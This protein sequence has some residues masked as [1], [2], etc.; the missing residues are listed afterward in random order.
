MSRFGSWSSPTL[1]VSELVQ[2]SLFWEIWTSPNFLIF[3]I[4]TS[5]D[6][7]IFEIWTSPDFLIFEIW[8]SPDFLILEIWTSPEF[9]SGLNIFTW[10]TTPPCGIGLNNNY[11]SFL[12][13][14]WKLIQLLF[15]ITSYYHHMTI[16]T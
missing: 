9:N 1:T 3:E 5:P 2:I 16:Y 12:S 13:S 11:L 8:T 6:F 4:W 15:V 7:L 10:D 14:T